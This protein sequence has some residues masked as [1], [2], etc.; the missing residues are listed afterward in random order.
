MWE[1]PT[2]LEYP[3]PVGVQMEDILRVKEYVQKR[4]KIEPTKMSDE[5]SFFKIFLCMFG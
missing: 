4:S 1:V 2:P 3:V 5:F